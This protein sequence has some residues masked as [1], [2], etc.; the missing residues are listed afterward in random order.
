ME[1]RQLTI[2][3]KTFGPHKGQYVA[4]V[5]F[6]DESSRTTLT[7]GPELG[8]DLLLMAGDAL[9]KYG[10]KVTDKLNAAIVNSIEAAEASQNQNEV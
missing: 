6:G 1:I 5:S 7:M 2:E 4:Q 3:L 8:N 9:K 10:S